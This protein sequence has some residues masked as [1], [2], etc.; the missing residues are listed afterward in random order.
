MSLRF[1][2][3]YQH[4]IMEEYPSCATGYPDS[5][6]CS[7]NT[8]LPNSERPVVWEHPITGEVRYPGRNDGEMPKYYKDQGYERHEMTSY[9]EHQKFNKEHG[10]INHAAEGIRDEALDK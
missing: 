4:K 6:R 8:Q 1:Q 5:I 2:Y 9:T 7:K 3:C 10:L